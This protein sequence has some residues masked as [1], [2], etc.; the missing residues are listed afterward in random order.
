M[1]SI[2]GT[3]SSVRAR[4]QSRRGLSKR[5]LYRLV[6]D[7]LMREQIALKRLAGAM[8]R[9]EELEPPTTAADPVQEVEG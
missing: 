4:L 7:V 5:E 2:F 1:T 6:Q 8:K 9:L 3:V